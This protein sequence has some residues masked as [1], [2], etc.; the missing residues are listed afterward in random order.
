M[1]SWAGTSIVMTRRSIRTMRS[2]PGMMYCR[3][4][5]RSPARRPRRNTTPRS[6]SWMTR[7]PLTRSRTMT[8]AMM[9]P[10]PRKPTISIPAAPSRLETVEASTHESRLHQ[11][12]GREL[13]HQS[14]PS[15]TDK[16]EWNARH[17]GEA[18]VRPKVRDGLKRD[19][20]DDARAYHSAKPV[21]CHVVGTDDAQK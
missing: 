18:N 9:P 2:T 14:A 5:I 20:R 3:P 1:A 11:P 8:I 17:R 15:V 4:G 21:I 19:H 13:R 12:D 6:Y 10:V 7:S 16:G